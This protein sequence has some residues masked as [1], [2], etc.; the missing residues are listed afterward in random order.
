MAATSALAAKLPPFERANGRATRATVLG[1]PRKVRFDDLLAIDGRLVDH[2]PRDSRE[3]NLDA[4]RPRRVGLAGIG[5]HSDV[6]ETSADRSLRIGTDEVRS[7][8]ATADVHFDREREFAA[9]GPLQLD[10]LKVGA[11]AFLHAEIDTRRRRE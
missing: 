2:R 10:R 11:F 7:F 3:R 8:V 6:D 4:P 9:I 1:R 5:S